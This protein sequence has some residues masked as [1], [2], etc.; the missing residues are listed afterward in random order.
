MAGVNAATSSRDL[1]IIHSV[2]AEPAAIE[3]VQPR[4]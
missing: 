1:P 4:V 2:S 3:A